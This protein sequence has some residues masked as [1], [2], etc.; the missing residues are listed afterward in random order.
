[1][2]IWT[3]QWNENGKAGQRSFAQKKL[4]VDFAVEK[5]KSPDCGAIGLWRLNAD[6]KHT[7][8]SLLAQ[9]HDRDAWWDTK[10]YE[11]TILKSG[12]LTRR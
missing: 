11:G 10:T 7:H 5:V 6:P 8:A 1:M 3:T 4:A 12:Q 2:N 9:S